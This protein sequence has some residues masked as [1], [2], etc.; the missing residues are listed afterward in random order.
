MLTFLITF[1]TL[2]GLLHL[3]FF[4]LLRTAYQPGRIAK[5]IAGAFLIFGVTSPLLTRLAERE[6]ME[7]LARWTALPG[8]YWM[9]VIFLFSASAAVIVPL[10]ML[11]GKVLL[12]DR[13]WLQRAR[14]L[15]PLLIAFVATIY[16]THE[17][18]SL[19]IEQVGIQTPKLPTGTV[20]KI[21]FISDLHIGLLTDDRRLEELVGTVNL[22]SPDIVISAGDLIDGYL[23]HDGTHILPLTKLSPRFGS[24]AITGNH[25]YYVGIDTAISLTRRAGFTLL[26][27]EGKETGGIVLLGEDDRTGRR[28]GSWRPLDDR[29]PPSRFRILLRH[30]P[31]LDDR[32]PADLQFSGHVHKGQIFPFNLI[33]WIRFR[34]PT[35]LHPL[36]DGT[37]LYT[38]RGTGTW[39][40]PVRVLA[41][42]EITLITLT[43]TGPPL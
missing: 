41:P 18:R 36:P 5:T 34:V 28:F 37:L 10:T 6:G 30:Q 1:F 42:P 9:S 7:N 2:Y 4:H 12:L 38:S 20:R 16:G 23:I 24:F 21:V 3:G 35:G 22:L 25:E 17:A 15:A 8:Y 11:M 13:H 31:F 32:P 33:T 14:F 40:P 26:R 43:G 29:T 27:G 39:G 19:K